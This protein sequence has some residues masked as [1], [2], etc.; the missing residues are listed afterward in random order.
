[1]INKLVSDASFAPSF[2]DAPRIFSDVLIFHPH[3]TSYQILFAVNTG[4][5]TRYLIPIF[6]S[7][8]LCVIT[9]HSLN[10]VTVSV[11]SLL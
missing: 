1:M 3:S 5:L 7:A 4:V 6:P 11:P 2:P 8:A 10:N 9:Y